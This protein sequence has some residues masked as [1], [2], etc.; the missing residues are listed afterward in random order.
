MLSMVPCEE[1]S[2]AVAASLFSLSIFIKFSKFSFSSLSSYK[3]RNPN[4]FKY[5]LVAQNI[6]PEEP[7][8]L[9]LLSPLSNFKDKSVYTA[10]VINEA[11][12]L[13]HIN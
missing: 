7:A 5:V 13:T 2:L 9:P 12:V 6:C 3:I 1:Y 4:S 8:L 10:S 11:S